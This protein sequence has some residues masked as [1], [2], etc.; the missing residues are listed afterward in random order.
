M[1]QFRVTC[2]VDLL[3]RF[4][5]GGECNRGSCSGSR[6]GRRTHSDSALLIGR[7]PGKLGRTNNSVTKRM[8]ARQTAWF[9]GALQLRH[10]IEHKL[11]ETILVE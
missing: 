9:E 6:E 10:D 11:S 8:K 4:R 1:I 5:D 3:N 2:G 7:D